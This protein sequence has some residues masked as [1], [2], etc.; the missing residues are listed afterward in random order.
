MIKQTPVR[1]A[2]FISEGYW[3]VDFCKTEELISGELCCSY[4]S[5]YLLLVSDGDY[6]LYKE[7]IQ[8]LIV[9][10]KG[11]KFKKPEPEATFETFKDALEYVYSL[12]EPTED[13]E[14]I[15]EL[16]EEPEDLVIEDSAEIEAEEISPVPPEDSINEALPVEIEPFEMMPMPVIM[17][18]VEAIDD[19]AIEDSIVDESEF[20]DI[21]LQ[22]GEEQL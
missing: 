18:D 11:R 22:E 16:T 5:R 14:L 17:T 3:K 7:D 13:I 19:Y 8:R 12:S 6:K 9:K 15:E 20:D 1:I 21:E 10:A 2:T 4:D